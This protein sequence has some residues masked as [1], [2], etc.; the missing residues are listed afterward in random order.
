[1]RGVRQYMWGGL[2]CVIA[3]ILTGCVAVPRTAHLS[4]T[5]GASRPVAAEISSYQGAVDA[6][7]SVMTN[8]L[9]IPVPATSLTLYFYPHREA[10][11]QG[12]TERFNTD[13]ALARDIA[14]SA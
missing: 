2:G 8:N 1:M 10:F 11:A 7:I 9:Q 14:K 13:P 3:T 12:L 4:V 5:P 6:I